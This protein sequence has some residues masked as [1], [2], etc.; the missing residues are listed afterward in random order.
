MIPT[1][2]GMLGFAKPIYPKGSLKNGTLCIA[3]MSLWLYR[4]TY[5]KSAEIPKQKYL[6]PYLYF[7]P[8]P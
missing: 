8:Q 4:S 2:F 6:R 1:R 7:I 3:K 5:G